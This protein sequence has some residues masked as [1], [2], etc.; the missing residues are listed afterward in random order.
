MTQYKVVFKNPE[1]GTM[2]NVVMNQEKAE[3]IQAD[4]KNKQMVTIPGYGMIS[5]IAV[6]A[7]VP[8]EKRT[9]QQEQLIN[10]SFFDPSDQTWYRKFEKVTNTKHNKQ[11]KSSYKTIHTMPLHEWNDLGYDQ[12]QKKISDIRNDYLLTK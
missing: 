4:K 2:Q 9:E 1:T 10:S 11:W 12:K 7:F 3:N 8:V 6:Q 5:H